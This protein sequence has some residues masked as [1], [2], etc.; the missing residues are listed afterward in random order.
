M[1][2]F[3]KT[4]LYFP[5]YNLLVFLT[6]VLP[7]GDLGL[8]IIILTLLVRFILFPLEHRRS[9]FQQAMKIIQPEIDELKKKFSTDREKLARETFAL[10]RRHGVNP[11]STVVIS[12]VQIPILLTL[13]FVFRSGLPFQATDLYSFVSLPDFVN[14]NFLGLIDLT[15]RSIP[16]SIFAGLTQFFQLRLSV[17]ALPIKNTNQPKSFSDDLARSMNINMRYFFPVMIT[18]ISLGFPAALVL[19]WSVS[20]LFMI[21]HEL[22]VRRKAGQITLP[23]TKSSPL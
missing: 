5:L 11:F 9:R 22:L 21:A 23:N 12:L 10:Y 19:Y 8:A 7:A 18:F 15:S 14:S 6:G 1:I 4:I 17:P 13:F 16:L 20:N 2:A 3:F